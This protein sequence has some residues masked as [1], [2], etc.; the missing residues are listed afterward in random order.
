MKD[1]IGESKVKSTN[2]PRELKISVISLQILVRN[3]SVKY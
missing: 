1:M 3:W 2:L